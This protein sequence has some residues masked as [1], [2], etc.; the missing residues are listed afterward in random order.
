MQPAR[1]APAWAPIRDLQ[2]VGRICP[3]RRRSR[4]EATVA[5]VTIAQARLEMEDL[6]AVADGAPVE[7]SGEARGTYRRGPGPRGEALTSGAA[8][9]RMTTQQ[10]F[11]VMSQSGGVGAPLPTPPLVRAALAVRLNGI[12]RGG[13]APG[14]WR[15]SSRPAAAPGCCP[16]PPLDRRWQPHVD[17]HA[18]RDDLPLARLRTT[19]PLTALVG[20]CS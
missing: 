11:L 7:L 10:L 3:V 17:R 16:T 6:L 1:A 9:Y 20:Y 13:P 8:V 2:H 5:P 15:T 14:M 18:R 12:A 19:Q 4:R